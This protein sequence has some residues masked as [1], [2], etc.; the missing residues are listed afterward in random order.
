MSLL[1]GTMGHIPTKWHQYLMS[2][3]SVSARIRHTH[4]DTRRDAAKNNTRFTAAILCTLL[5]MRCVVTYLQRLETQLRQTRLTFT[6]ELSG[7]HHALSC[8]HI[9]HQRRF[10]CHYTVHTLCVGTGH[11]RRNGSKS[12]A[13][14][15][16]AAQCCTSRAF[17]FKWEW[18]ATSR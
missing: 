7:Q 12:S 1:D 16:M 11:R 15:E 18:G 3:Y 10:Y 5:S 17:A 13:A 6:A 8:E 9:I 14:A 2:G 4:T